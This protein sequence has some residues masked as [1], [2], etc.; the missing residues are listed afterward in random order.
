[1]QEILIQVTNEASLGDTASIGIFYF[2]YN[3]YNQADLT[4]TDNASFDIG[5]NFNNGFYLNRKQ[6]NGGNI[7]TGNFNVTTGRFFYNQYNANIHT[8]NFN[9]TAGNYFFNQ[10]YSTINANNFNITTGN[11]FLNEYAT[12]NA[13]DFNVTAGEDFS[14]NSATISAHNFNVTAGE[15]FENENGATIHA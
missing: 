5:L 12:I 10:Y 13:D 8:N 9:V 6:Y 11:Y 2:Q 14:N 7:S 1:M 3:F 15:D 4:I